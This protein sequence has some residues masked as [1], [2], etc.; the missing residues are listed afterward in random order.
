LAAGGRLYEAVL[1]V[2]DLLPLPRIHLTDVQA[3]RFAY[4][5]LVPIDDGSVDGRT[6]VLIDGRLLGIG[7]VVAGVLH[8]ETVVAV[9][10]RQ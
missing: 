5:S 8:P 2:A 7:R 6:V 9:E 3:Q 10:V 1:P 4:G